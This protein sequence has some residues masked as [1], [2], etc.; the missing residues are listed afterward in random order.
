MYYAKNIFD[1]IMTAFNLRNLLK[2]IVLI[3]FIVSIFFPIKASINPTNIKE[4]IAQNKFEEALSQIENSIISEVKNP[5]NYLHR[6]ILYL[7]LAN[8]YWENN[9]FENTLEPNL[10]AI[11]DFNKSLEIYNQSSNK[12]ISRE[13]LTILFANKRDALYSLAFNFARKEKK[14]AKEI[15][16]QSLDAFSNHI[17]LAPSVTA[18]KKHDSSNFSTEIL[19]SSTF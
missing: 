14:K 16:K 19:L 5:L 1:G 8:F 9:E 11:N 6:G 10:K 17:E 2:K 3:T 18:S 13:N 4:Q 15:F 12:N 7:H